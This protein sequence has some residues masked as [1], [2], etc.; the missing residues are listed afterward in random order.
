M[1]Y[2]LVNEESTIHYPIL[3]QK[4]EKGPYFMKLGPLYA[5]ANTNTTPDVS[6]VNDLSTKDTEEG[7]YKSKKMPLQIQLY[8]GGFSIIGLYIIYKLIRKSNAQ[9]I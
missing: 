7:K 4:E 8:L 3:R 6:T 2:S 5:D 9:Y 1:N